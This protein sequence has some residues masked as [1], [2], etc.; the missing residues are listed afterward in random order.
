MSTGLNTDLK[1]LYRAQ[2]R[3]EKLGAI[4][5][6]DLLDGVLGEL[7][8]QTHRRIQEEKYGPDGTQWPN[9]LDS[10]AATRHSGH[11]LLMGE[12][13]LD[14]SLTSLIIDDNSGAMG[15]NL[16]YAATHQFGDEDRNIVAR[17]FLGISQENYDD[18][19]AIVDDFL[20]AHIAEVMQ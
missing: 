4:A 16:I 18:L 3:I 17:P 10:Y 13:D 15:S 5:K 11:S 2:Q 12:G 14:D 6:R 19:A 20:D 1:G 7:E 8:D 9:W